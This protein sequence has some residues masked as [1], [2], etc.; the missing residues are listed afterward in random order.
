[1]AENLQKTLEQ[2]KE[3]LAL[4]SHELKSPLA[5][6]RIAL[7]LIAEKNEDKPETIEIIDGI[8]GEI[9]ESEKLIEQLLVLSRVEMT[10]PSSIREPFDAT[11]VARQAADQVLP[12]AQA[13]HI[14][15]DVNASQ[16]APIRG[17]STQILR[18]LVNVLENAIKFSTEG[19]T[20][21]LK[22]EQLQNG[23]EVSVADSGTGIPADERE[24]IFE[25]FYRGTHNGDKEGS[26]LGLY[27]ARKIVE[28]HGGTI[29]AESNGTA[30]TII[31][32]NLP[33]RL[34]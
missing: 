10:L 11:A 28:L 15:I 5:R 31:R 12:L 20:V 30:G 13:A 34:D 18:A 27:I 29:R 14:K 17:D 19:S 26:G 4:I 25:P 21:S 16:V 8:K 1:M 6:M 23:I 24:K 3:F 2:R 9:T 7:E 22:V 32:I 33:A